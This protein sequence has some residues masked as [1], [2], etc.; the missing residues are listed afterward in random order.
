MVNQMA[1]IIEKANINSKVG[2]FPTNID[3]VGHNPLPFG[4]VSIGSNIAKDTLVSR[5][6][7]AAIAMKI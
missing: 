6:R 5:L 3:G 2:C 7:N 1:S 4:S